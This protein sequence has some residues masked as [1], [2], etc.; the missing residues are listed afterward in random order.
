MLA[1]GWS[2]SRASAAPVSISITLIICDE[3]GC[4]LACALTR[5][6]AQL[7]QATPEFSAQIRVPRSSP[8]PQAVAGSRFAKKTAGET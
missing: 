1:V 5:G 4:G 3:T 2:A 7:A 8:L 6:A